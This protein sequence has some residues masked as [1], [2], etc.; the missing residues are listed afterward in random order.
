MQIKHLLHSQIDF[1]KWDKTILSSPYP[2]VF[3]QSFY[4]NATCP[5]WEALI[6][7]DYESIFPLTKSEKLGIAYLHQP[8]FTPQLG[9]YGNVNQQIEALLF[10]YI[11]AKFKLIEIELNASNQ[12]TSQYHIPKTT[13]IIDFKLP[14]KQNQNTKRN[15]TKATENGLL[16][17]KVEYNDVIELSKIYL[18]PFLSKTL[19]LSANTITKFNSLLQNAMN[20]NNLYTFKVTDSA[21]NVKALAHFISNG[22][23]TVYLKGT[24]FDKSENSGSM[25]LL[26]ARA[27]QFFEDKSEF[28]DFGGGS[29]ES[30]AQF[31]K[32]FGA[33]PL[34]YS[35]IKMNNLPWLIKLLKK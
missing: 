15:I 8:A 32:G 28:F 12:F 18:N 9:V 20:T 19:H 22:K 30:L 17:S 25:H 2:L 21:N 29:K 13:Y 6:I 4:L 26:T 33:S 16:F 31:Y 7:G 35:T 27:I 5:N 3:A 34:N 1:E 24:N 11:T 23:H 10:N 14:I